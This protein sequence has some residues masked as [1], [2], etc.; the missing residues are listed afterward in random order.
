MSR[1]W[2]CA[3]AGVGGAENFAKAGPWWRKLSNSHE[4]WLHCEWYWCEFNRAW[5]YYQWG[6]LD[7]AKTQVA[8]DI[9]RVIGADTANFELVAENCGG[10]REL[11]DRF[12][13]LAKQL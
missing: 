6:K 11:R 1:S 10:D 8:R 3:V 9:V 5:T 7:S 12:R 2:W 13:W 4:K